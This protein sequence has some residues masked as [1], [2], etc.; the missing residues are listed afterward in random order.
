M[1][2]FAGPSISPLDAGLFYDPFTSSELRRALSRC[3]ESA[4]GL[5]SFPY[6]LF[7]VFFP[8]WQDALVKLFNLAL[9]WGT[10]P[11]L[12]KHSVVV[13]IFKQGNPSIPDNFRPVS[14]ASCCFK[15]LEHL[16]HMRIA[17]F[18]N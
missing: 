6:F 12:W 10:V 13:P 8:W 3:V 11:S 17:L 14:L 18:I 2:R 5:D 1:R 15:V 9:A 16:I 4:V 7:K